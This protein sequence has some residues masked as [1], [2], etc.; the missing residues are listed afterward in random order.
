MAGIKISS[1]TTTNLGPLDYFPVARAGSTFKVSSLDLITPIAQLSAAVDGMLGAVSPILNGTVGYVPMFATPDILTTGSMYDDIINRYIGIGTS[2]PLR[3]LHLSR[4]HSCE[5][6]IEQTNALADYKKWNFVVDLGSPVTASNFYIRQLNDAAL[7]GHIPFHIH[8]ATHEVTISALKVDNRITANGLG[9]GVDDTVVIRDASGNLKTAE[10]NPLVW[11]ATLGG[12]NGSGTAGNLS[13][14]VDTDEIGD[15]IVSET[16]TEVTVSGNLTVGNA[17]DINYIKFAGVTGDGA[18]HSYL[19][20]RLYDADGDGTVDSDTSELVLAKGNDVVAPVGPDRIR[21]A[22]PQLVFDTKPAAT[23]PVP[24]S[25]DELLNGSVTRM[26]IQPNGTVGIGTTNPNANVKLHVEGD[27]QIGGETALV[28]G[29]T[30]SKLYFA[31]GNPAENSDALWIARHRAV[32]DVTELRINIADNSRE[33]QDSLSVGSEAAGVWTQWLSVFA[34]EEGGVSHGAIKFG[35][36]NTA[37][38][39]NTRTAGAGDTI[40]AENEFLKV[41]TPTGATRYIRLYSI[42]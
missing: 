8:G 7:G 32:S 41:T 12:I 19:A 22:A 10:I 5:I 39:G 1:F 13:K 34:G 4:E 24:T 2:V 40:T 18:S 30:G 33:D 23:V 3:R 35:N 16:G 14:W 31:S 9:V 36:S 11:G 26:V 38:H 28:D 20:E 21:L 29:G 42:T 17:V 15:S 25:I 6:I 37:I 27:V